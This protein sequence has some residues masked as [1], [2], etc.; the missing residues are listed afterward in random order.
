[1][2]LQRLIEIIWLL[3]AIVSVIVFFYLLFT[4]GFIAGKAYIYIITAAAGSFMFYVRRRQ[5]LMRNTKK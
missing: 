1:M 4:E 2:I 3:I 5:R